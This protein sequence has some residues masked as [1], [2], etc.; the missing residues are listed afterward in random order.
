MK[1]LL[2]KDFYLATQNRIFLYLTGAIVVA[3]VFMPG[4]SVEFMIPYP[5][6]M[7]VTDALS[8]ISYDEFDNGY[9]AL[10]TLPITRKQ[11]VCE[12]YLLVLG[13]GALVPFTIALIAVA[14]G[15]LKAGALVFIALVLLL[16]VVCMGGFALPC[17]L[18]FGIEK[19]R[20]V[21]IAIIMATT[22]LIVTL[23]DSAV[24]LSQSAW[25]Q[26]PL[27]PWIACVVMVLI[28]SVSFLIAVK[29]MERKEL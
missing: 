26:N 23:S 3:M 13:L 14:L 21:N 29:I 6:F 8:T 20:V 19:G 18:K 25:L 2:I 4:G 17:Y 10:F 12:K 11:Y 5:A 9:K 15:A 27:V 16:L 24:S 7:L 22:F 1:G 28:L